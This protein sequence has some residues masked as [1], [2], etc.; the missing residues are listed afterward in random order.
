MRYEVPVFAWTWFT[1]PVSTIWMG[2]L[3]YDHDTLQNQH[4]CFAGNVIPAWPNFYS[5]AVDQ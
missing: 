1:S 5:L 4:I 2:P 3:Q